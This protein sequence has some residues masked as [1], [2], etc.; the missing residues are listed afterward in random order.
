MPLRFS[1]RTLLVY[2]ACWAIVLAVAAPVVR[3]MGLLFCAGTTVVVAGLA[4]GLMSHAKQRTVRLE[5]AAWGVPLAVLVFATVLVT[6][7]AGGPPAVILLYGM[8]LFFGVAVI[9][10]GP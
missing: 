3:N 1:V 6:A 8:L 10:W 2:V 4:L 9:I 7:N 5:E